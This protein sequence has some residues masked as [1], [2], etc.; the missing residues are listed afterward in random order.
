MTP[1]ELTLL[2]RAGCHLCDVMKTVVDRVAATHPLTL[3][4]VDIDTDAALRQKYDTEIPVLLWGDRV[5]ARY[6]VSASQLVE[7]LTA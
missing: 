4:V 1:P 2:T 6:R 5:L 3:R 7:R